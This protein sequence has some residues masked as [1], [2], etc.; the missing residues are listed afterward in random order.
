MK[1]SITILLAFLYITLTGGFSVNVHYCMGKLASVDFKSHA[2]DACNKCGK[3][4][5]K[6]KCCRDEARFCKVDISSHVVAKVHQTSEPAVKD[7]S[8]PVVILPV[9][10][11]TV[12]LFTAYYHHGPPDDEPIPLYIQHCT[13]LI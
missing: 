13:Y 8:L 12:P 4:G 11:L 6:N 5:K 3:S 7:L 10:E 9:P 2:D 1:R